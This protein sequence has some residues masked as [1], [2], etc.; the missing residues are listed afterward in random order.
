MS[1]CFFRAHAV[2]RGY[3]KPIPDTYVDSDITKVLEKEEGKKYVSVF[4]G[5]LGKEFVPMKQISTNNLQAILDAVISSGCVPV[6]LGDNKDHE[7]FWKRIDISHPSIINH[8]GKLDI[9]DSASVL[10]QCDRFVSN[11][12]GL[13]HIAGAL[14]VRGL[15][16]WGTT[17]FYKNATL[18]RGIAKVYMKNVSSFKTCVRDYLEK[19]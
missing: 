5:C 16:F 1:Q 6:L 10:S 11:D 9:K 17:D 15:I 7:R 2:R 4:H 3:S 19:I 8:I 12:T 13:T 18:F 14:K